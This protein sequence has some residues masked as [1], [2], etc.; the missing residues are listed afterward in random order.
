MNMA[1]SFADQVTVPKDV[2]LSGVEGES[3]LLN[4]ESERYFGL[5][6]VGTRM[7]SVLTESKSIQAAYEA[8]L[9]EYNVDAEALRQDLVSLIDKLIDQG[10]M[11][12]TGE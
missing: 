9:D 3:V 10:L 2:L 12:I 8:L 11:E 6:E 5:D 4:L 7:L 1:I